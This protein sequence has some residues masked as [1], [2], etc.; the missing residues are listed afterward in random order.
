M[1]IQWLLA[2]TLVVLCTAYLLRRA[3]K[4]WSAKSSCG[5]SCGCHSAPKAN[6]EMTLIPSDQLRLRSQKP[7]GEK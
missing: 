3:W 7:A 6:T 1:E 4:T 5:G 2:A